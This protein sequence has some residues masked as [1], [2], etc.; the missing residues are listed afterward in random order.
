MPAT[1]TGLA[2]FFVAILPGALYTWAFEREIGRWGIGLT[3]RLLRFVGVSALF[4]ALT[5]YPAHYVW[6]NYL[7]APS[8]SDHARNLVLDGADLPPWLYFVP[9]GYVSV[10]IAL[11][12]LAAVAVRRKWWIARPLVG[13]DPAPRAWDFLFAEHPHG[14]VRVRLK[15]EEGWIGGLFRDESY[16]AGYPEEPQDLYL[17][18]TYKM[19]KSGEFAAD[20]NGNFIPLGSGILVRWED[21][22]HLEFFHDPDDQKE[23]HEE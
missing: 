7:H 14:V 23:Q 22:L 6:R 18:E 8:D 16:A 12:S 19:L 13:A 20:G 2:L 3:D 1:I 11:G 17:E 10:P 4:L 21:V 9:V 15:D 5:T